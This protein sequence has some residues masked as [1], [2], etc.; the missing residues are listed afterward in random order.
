MLFLMLYSRILLVRN[1]V[2]DDVVYMYVNMF[3]VGNVY[4]DVDGT[5]THRKKRW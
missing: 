4:V 3:V 1:V 2:V 5:Q